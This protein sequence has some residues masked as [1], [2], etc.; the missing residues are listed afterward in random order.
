MGERGSHPVRRTHGPREVLTRV[1]DAFLSILLAPSCAACQLPLDRPT[2][3]AVC[4]ACWQSILPFTPPLCQRCGDPLASWRSVDHPLCVRCRSAPSTIVIA[5]AAGEYAGALRAIVHAFKY[6]GRRSLAV[7]VGALMRARGSEALAGADVVV[8][9][10]LHPS[11]RRARG[12]NQADDL[13]RQLHLP[14]VAAL[15]RTRATADQITLPAPD[16]RRNMRQAFAATQA[17]RELRGCAV[18]IVDDVST[19]GATLEACAEAL[20][21]CGVAEVRALT[22]ARVPS[23]P[24]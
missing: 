2:R 9:V 22:A 19:T 16:R 21:A 10:P 6:D 23:G 24:R 18:V 20:L 8:P 15:Q 3:G 14:T 7:P 4:S 13:A 5:R 11:R 17:A 1:A 12:F